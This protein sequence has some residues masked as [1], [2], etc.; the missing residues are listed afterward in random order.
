MFTSSPH[1]TPKEKCFFAPF[2]HERVIQVIKAG[3]CVNC[4]KEIP[5]TYLNL[6][7]TWRCNY[8]CIGCIDGGVVG[9]SEILKDT[10][11]DMDWGLASHILAYA[12]RHNLLGFIVQGG[13]PLLYPRIDEFL[14][15]CA[16]HGLV[17]RLVTNG[18]QILKHSETLIRAFQTPK[19]MIRV[20]INADEEHYSSFTR[21][22]A[23]LRTIL[24]GIETIVNAGANVVVGTVVFGRNLEAKGFVS[25]TE[26]ID[27]I[28]GEVSSVGARALVLLPGRHPETKE[29]VLFEKDELDAL[30]SLAS[31]K[32]S[33][34]VIL[35]GRFVVERELPARDQIK[36]YVPCPT[37]LL[38]IVVGCDGRLFN[39][40]EHR[41][42]SDAEIGRVSKENTFAEVWHSE[43][44][45]RRQ[46]QFD[47]RIHCERITCDRHGINTT[48]EI[49]RRGYEEFGCPSIIRHV[50]M[51]RDESIQ[52][53]F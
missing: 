13:E 30:D 51:D 21:S 43:Q 12:K 8:D 23:D 45:V 26:Q 47:P 27:R 41:G 32:S 39:C 40:T 37:A 33:T 10:S 46:L 25:N 11:L 34:S 14:N 52:P 48:V 44:R 50:L 9:R 29:M 6:D 5:P 22:K 3:R 36:N 18:S 15:C 16:E 28:F 17:L 1:I 53:F 31:R 7:V 42:E 35:G 24:E 4:L 49:A 19:S 2:N 20:S 38:R